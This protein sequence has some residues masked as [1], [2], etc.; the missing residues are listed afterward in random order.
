MLPRATSPHVPR[1][2]TL[3]RIRFR[4]PTPVASACISP[5]LSCTRVSESL[6]ILNDA[7]SRCSSVPWSFSS[8]VWRICSNFWAFSERSTSSRPSTV[9]RSASC[10]VSDFRVSSVIATPRR[11]PNC[12]SV[13]CTS[14]RKALALVA[15]SSR[16][17]FEPIA[18]SCRPRASSSRSTCSRLCRCA[19]GLWRTRRRMAAASAATASATARPAAASSSIDTWAPECC[20]AE[21]IERTWT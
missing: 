11:S 2:L 9:L 15:A 1:D 6:T 3:P 19:V 16:N 8:T 7:P 17:I 20:Q 18:L 12:C 4:S 13:C 21:N 5:T 14:S 10:W